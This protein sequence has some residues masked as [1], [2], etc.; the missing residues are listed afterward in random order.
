MDTTHRLKVFR[1]VRVD[2][3]NGGYDRKDKVFEVAL[4]DGQWARVLA[5][6]GAILS[7]QNQ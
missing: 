3:A 1:Q 5:Q 4:T 2:T 6:I 7:E